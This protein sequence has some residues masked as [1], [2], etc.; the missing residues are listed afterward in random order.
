MHRLTFALATAAMLTLTGATP[1]GA[2][3]PADFPS[4][5]VTLV[6]PTAPSVTGD[7]LMRAFAE[8]ASKHLGQSII[9]ENKPGGSATLA[10]AHVAGNA[11]P[12]GYTITQIVIP[13]FRVPVMQKATYDPVK[14]F[15]YIIML[16][17]YTLGAVVKADSP[18]KS[19]QDVMAFAEANPGRF[20]YTTVGP[21]T[22][23]AIA[24]ETIARQ[25]GVQFTHVP[26]KGGGAG[27]AAVLGGHVMAMVESPSWAPTVASGDLRLLMLLNGERSRKWPD[28][29]TLKDLGYH[30]DFDSPFGL[31]G[32]KGMD[33]AIVKT[34][35]GAFKKA[36]DDPKVIDAY[37]KFDFV[38]RYMNTEDY[39]KFVPKLA[40]NERTAMEKI[41]LVKVGLA[42]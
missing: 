25:A 8:V 42:K 41:G 16:G 4:R 19:W 14:D 18:F 13:V 20:T 26:G 17:G 27:I 15:T 29:P 31:A 2:E 34:L 40:A 38:R 21:M 6:V 36:Y 7:L 10:A 11:K 1:T 23:N 32:P 30:Y 24:M 12:D 37:E 39:Q 3:A 28:T 33:P 35:H 9:V 22:T 5:P